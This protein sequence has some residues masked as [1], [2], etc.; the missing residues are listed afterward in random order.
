MVDTSIFHSSNTWHDHFQI[1]FCFYFWDGVSLYCL[2][3]MQWHNLSS[4]Q[5]PPPRFKQFSCLSLP[6]SWDYWCMPLCPAKFCIFSRDGVL[7][8]W[9]GWSWTP[10]L[11]WSAHLGLPKC[12][13]NRCEPLRLPKRL[14]LIYRKSTSHN[15]HLFY[16]QTQI[17]AKFFKSLP[18]LE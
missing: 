6:S 17:S 7:P 8:C 16:S 1:I 4:L 3:G 10:D 11:G 12:W 14:I 5:P 2:A 13:N 15:H 9:P 18:V